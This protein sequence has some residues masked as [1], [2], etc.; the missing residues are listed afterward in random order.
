MDGRFGGHIGLGRCYAACMD[1]ALIALGLLGIAALLMDG[2]SMH[3][4]K[5]AAGRGD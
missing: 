2:P 4:G 3:G 1:L 5:H